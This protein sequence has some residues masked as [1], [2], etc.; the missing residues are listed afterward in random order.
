[1]GEKRRKE[2]EGENK[3]GREEKERRDIFQG[4]VG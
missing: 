4:L 1:M 2:K 3:R